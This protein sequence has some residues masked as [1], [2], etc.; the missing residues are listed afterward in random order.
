MCYKILECL[1]IVDI[2]FFLLGILL[3]IFS[4]IIT[5]RFFRPNV[6]IGIPYFESERLKIPIKNLSTKNDATNIK[7]E[8]AGVLN[9]FTYH[10]KC[11]RYDFLLLPKFDLN[12]S[13]KPYERKFHAIDIDDYTKDIASNCKNLNDFIELLKEEKAYLRVRIHANHEFTG[14][15][16]SFEK[17]FKLEDE[18]F[19]EITA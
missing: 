14:F 6:A 19:K 9:E 18:G 17:M 10:L 5:I 7:I 12:K 15:G 13:D 1:S 11:D 3:A 2:V 16:K 8:A 4:T